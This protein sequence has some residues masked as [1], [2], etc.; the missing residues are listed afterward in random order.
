M[1]KEQ[2]P[3]PVKSKWALSHKYKMDQALQ[4][5]LETEDVNIH[6]R[7]TKGL[8]VV[9]VATNAGSW[10]KDREWKFAANDIYKSLELQREAAE[11]KILEKK[12]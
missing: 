4:S 2:L 11:T 8:F 3:G 7:R 9:D 5:S 12:K 1:L 6:K 10:M